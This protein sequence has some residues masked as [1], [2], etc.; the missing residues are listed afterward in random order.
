MNP[1]EHPLWRRSSPSPTS[2]A[3]LLDVLSTLNNYPHSIHNPTTEFRTIPEAL[4]AGARSSRPATPP[5]TPPLPQPASPQPEPASPL[6]AEDEL[7]EAQMN[8]LQR[9]K[10]ALLSLHAQQKTSGG[11]HN[12][13]VAFPVADAADVATIRYLLGH[14]SFAERLLIPRVKLD[15]IASPPSVRIVACGTTH[16]QLCVALSE[17]LLNEIHVQWATFAHPDW[18]GPG[19]I[20]LVQAPVIETQLVPGARCRLQADAGLSLNGALPWL[21]LD[22]VAAQAESMASI[23]RRRDEFLRGSGGRVRIY[24][25]LE[26]L[27]AVEYRACEAEKSSRAGHPQWVPKARDTAVMARED[28]GGFVAAQIWAWTTRLRPGARLWQEHPDLE[29][30]PLSRRDAYR[31]VWPEYAV[32]EDFVV[33][34]EDVV[35]PGIFL[36]QWREWRTTMAMKG[37]RVEMEDIARAVQEVVVVAGACVQLV[38]GASAIASA[39]ASAEV[40]VEVEEYKA[41]ELDPEPDPTPIRKPIKTLSAYIPRISD[42]NGAT[43]REAVAATA[44]TAAVGVQAEAEAGAGAIAYVEKTALDLEPD[45]SP[46]PACRH[47]KPSIAYPLRISDPNEDT[48][49]ADDEILIP[50]PTRKEPRDGPVPKSVPRICDEQKTK[51]T[52]VAGDEPKRE[53]DNRGRYGRGR[54]TGRGRGWATAWRRRGRGQGSGAT[55]A[56]AEGWRPWGT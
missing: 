25:V 7:S 2:K 32:D 40:E 28:A 1:Y 50:A 46:S 37:L 47:R 29:I 8:L 53:G 21:L 56:P 12:A 17:L 33:R 19:H 9:L 22:V 16:T 43:T 34:L 6:I 27:T 51:Y 42:S 49:S 14:V 41:L 24:V 15:F 30:V 4:R 20:Q 39:S 31:P 10:I 3:A 52:D 48:S 5:P 18:P 11:A 55:D 44:A 45:S 23:E 36:T 38:P 26:L 13:V 35:G 54:G